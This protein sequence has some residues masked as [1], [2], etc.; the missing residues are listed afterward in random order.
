MTTP[1]QIIGLCGPAGAGKDTVRAI[2]E[3]DHGFTG[4]AFADPIR[5]MVGALLRQIDAEQ[6]MLERDLKEE[7]IPG[8]NVSYRELAQTLGTEWGRE[9]LGSYFWVRIA[10]QRIEQLQRQGA[11]RIVISDV[12]FS[13]EV[14]MVR[15][16]GGRIW[17]ITRPGIPPV[18]Q[19]PSEALA[20]AIGADVQIRNDSSIDQL[21]VTVEQALCAV[22]VGQ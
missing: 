1:L 21:W 8:L 16:L 12:R 13:N 20:N 5:S 10:Q 9:T 14:Q 18:R 2:L 7:H 3:S 4:L 6:Y 15:E 17:R 11:R 22:G 19:H